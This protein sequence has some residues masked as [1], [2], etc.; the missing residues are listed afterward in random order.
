MDLWAYNGFMRKKLSDSEMMGIGIGALVALTTAGLLGAFRGALGRPNAAL[1][2][3]LVVVAA[4]AIGGRW[5]GVATGLIAAAGFDFFLTRPYGSLAIKSSEDVVTTILLVLV[6]LAVGTIAIAERTA[7]HEGRTG[8]EEVAGLYRVARLSAE[9]AETEAVVHAIEAEV[10]SVMHLRSCRFERLA[11]DVSLP[12][13]ELSGRIDTPYVF[14]GDGFALPVE[15]M[16]VPVRHGEHAL[17]WL[18]CHPVDGS[19]GVSRDRRR[20]AL[21]LADHLA[22]TLAGRAA[23]GPR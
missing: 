9:G 8:T 1:V 10:A 17:G 5:A 23:S 3:V 15:G 22:L 11:G 2:L 18:V 20:T 6:G 13:L 14:E 12:V 4:A 19:L 16:R 7:R 21:V